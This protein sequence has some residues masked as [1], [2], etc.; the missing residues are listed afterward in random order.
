MT[1]LE[2]ICRAETLWPRDH[3]ITVTRANR[4]TLP[5]RT[6]WYVDIGDTADGCQLAHGLDVNGHVTCGHPDCHEAERQ[7]TS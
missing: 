5:G 3:N 2:A 4:Q 1:A 7:A 6:E